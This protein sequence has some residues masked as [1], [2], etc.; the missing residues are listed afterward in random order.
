MNSPLCWVGGKS[1]LSSQIIERIPDHTCYVEPFAGAAWVLFLKEPSKVEVLNDLNSDLVTLYRVLQNHLVEFVRQFMWLLDSREMFSD[2]KNQQAAPG[3]TD[4]QRAA[5]FY[6]TQKLSFGGQVVGQTFGA[7]TT[8]PPGLNLLRIEQ[9]LSAAHLRLA[10]VL[11]EHLPYVD[12]IR[13]YD[14][15][16]TFFYCDPPYEGCENQYGKEMFSAADYARLA[17]LL[18]GI[19]GKFLLSINSSSRIRQV[20]KAFN[21]EPVKTRYSCGTKGRGRQIKELLIS[22]F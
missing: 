17:E 3:L 12:L 20:F 1:R 14:R 18:G 8:H 22:N 19:K 4:I 6:Y 13:R 21:I 10:R 9:E 11:I 7:S 16:H 5:R 15:E 2:F